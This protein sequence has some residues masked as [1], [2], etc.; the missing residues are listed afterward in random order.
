MIENGAGPIG[1]K[2]MSEDGGMAVAPAKA[3]ARATGVRAQDLPLTP[4]RVW[5]ALRGARMA[6][7]AKRSRA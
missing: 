3:V 2:G 4:A 1:G 5:A 7:A 6:Q